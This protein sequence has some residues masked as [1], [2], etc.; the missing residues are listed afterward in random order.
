[1]QASRSTLSTPVQTSSTVCSAKL[2]HAAYCW[3]AV[4]PAHAASTN[5]IWPWQ[6]KLWG[7]LA[8]PRARA[9]S[10]TNSG[11]Q[12]GKRAATALARP[13]A[14]PACVIMPYQTRRRCSGGVPPSQAPSQL[15]Q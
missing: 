8:R 13:M 15:P 1:M 6:M 2:R 12:S 10:A 9:M 14:T 11:P 7:E 5:Q 3:C 4:R